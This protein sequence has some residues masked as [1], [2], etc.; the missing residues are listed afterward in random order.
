MTSP[1]PADHPLPISPDPNISPIA[2]VPLALPPDTPDFTAPPASSDPSPETEALIAS[3][4]SSL[5]TAQHTI[6]TQTTRL[7]S[8]SDVETELGQLKDQYAFLSA[9]KEAVETQLQEE[10]KK[11]EVA[12]ENVEMLRGQVEQARRGVMTLQKQEA[13]RKRMSTISGY[14]TANG[15]LGLGLN[16]EEEILSSATERDSA[17][18]RE[19]KLVKR[20]SIMRSHRRQSSQSEPSINELHERGSLVTSPNMQN[21]RDPS[22]TLRPIGQGG[23]RELRLGHTPP[24][25]TLPSANLPSP[26]V[27]L[28]GANNPHQ[29]GYFDDHTSEPPS[30]VTSKT[31]E[32]PFKKEI[33]AVEEAT[34][35]RNEL[36]VL[37]SELEESEEAR[38]ASES[39]L[40]ALREFMAQDPNSTTSGEGEGG[41]EMTMSTADLLKGIRLPP[42][43]TDRDADEEQRNAEAEKAKPAAGGWGF[44]LWNAKPTSPGKEVPHG[45][46]SPQQKTLSPIENRS[47]AGSTATVSPLPTP[48]TD[49]IA[50]P[51]SGLTAS[52][53]VSSQTPL[54][55][56]VSNWTK[57][58]TSPPTT[59]GISS[60]QTE[61]PTNSRKISVTNFFSR[62]AKKEVPPSAEALKEEKELPT[63]PEIVGAEDTGSSDVKISLEPSPEIGTR[64]LIFEDSRRYSKG[65]SGTTVTELEDELGTPQSSL[66]G[67]EGEGDKEKEKEKM[68]EVAL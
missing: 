3:L 1:N 34:K 6:S 39:C 66:K 10:I 61:R 41:G 37:Q 27:P 53:T 12:E 18:S 11:R 46:V 38:M 56:F 51:T 67:A 54:S 17:S 48:A 28:S 24:S 19:S 33:E 31:S 62:G 50:T 45:A 7:S 63:P 15:V 16:G 8:L 22:G 47:R 36:S 60:P 32:L 23:L 30:S 49:D 35:L 21:S 59:A 5:A 68:E 43:P 64:E 14:S 40:K 2:T 29:S 55:S 25:A 58:V 65:T 44:K 4:Q 57:G 26:N 13:D 9:A 52:T 42:L 20:Q